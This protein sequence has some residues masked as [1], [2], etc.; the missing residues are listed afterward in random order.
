MV[1][2]NAVGGEAGGLGAGGAVVGHPVVEVGPRSEAD[3]GGA[4]PLGGV[5]DQDRAGGA[6]E[7]GLLDRGLEQFGGARAVGQ[8]EAG[9]ADHRKV[10]TKLGKPVRG[11]A[12]DEGAADRADFAAQRNETR[13]ADVAGG[14]ERELVK[15]VRPVRARSRR[16]AASVVDPASMKTVAP[17]GISAAAVA[18]R[19]ALTA[20][21]VRTLR[22]K[23]GSPDT[24]SG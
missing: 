3:R 10:E 24:A 14:E 20:G 16:P 12:A 8:V 17:S 21:T 5:G 19:A 11:E 13:P 7:G 4:R 18:A 15:T 23:A 6:R 1:E 22:A 2:S 9:G